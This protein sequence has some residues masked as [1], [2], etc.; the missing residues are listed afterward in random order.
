MHKSTFK[1]GDTVS[2]IENGTVKV[3]WIDGTKSKEM[4]SQLYIDIYK[5]M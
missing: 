2:K 5:N 4:T 3:Q 1:V